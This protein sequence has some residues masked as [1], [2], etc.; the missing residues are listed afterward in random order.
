MVLPGF[1]QIQNILFSQVFII[2]YRVKFLYVSQV[3]LL[4]RP[5]NKIPCLLIIDSKAGRNSL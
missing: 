2:N 4:G 5:G 1:T 3:R